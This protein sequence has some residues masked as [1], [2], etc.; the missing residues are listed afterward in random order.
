MTKTNDY[1]KSI[2]TSIMAITILTSVIAMGNIP[3]AH[4]GGGLLSGYYAEENWTVQTSG[5]G[6]VTFFNADFVRIIGDDSDIGLVIHPF[7]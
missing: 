1:K 2:L 5:D 6:S 4:A 7:Q 3:K